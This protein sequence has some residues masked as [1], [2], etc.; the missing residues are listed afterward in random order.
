MKKSWLIAAFVAC[1]AMLAGCSVQVVTA[2]V[3]E[4]CSGGDCVAGTA[5]ATAN[6]TSDGFTGTYCTAACDP[7]NPTCP[8]DGTGISAVCVSDPGGATGQCYAGCPSGT[9][10]PYG[11][12]CSTLGG[13]INF[14]VP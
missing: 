5:C 12:A 4:V 8:D 7:A 9:G 13:G 2:G 11:E 10:C 1:T 14:C 6:V 3:Y